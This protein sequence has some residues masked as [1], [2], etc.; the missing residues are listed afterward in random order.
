MHLEVLADAALLGYGSATPAAARIARAA[1]FETGDL[2]IENLLVEVGETSLTKDADGLI[3]LDVFKDFVI[4]LDSPGRRLEL[5]PF[6]ARTPD[7]KSR[8]CDGCMRAYRLGSLLL[9]HGTINGHADGYFVLDSGSPYS[10]VSGKLLPQDGRPAT[11]TG[12][13]GDQV[14]A[15]HSTPV[16]IQLGQRHLMDFEYATFDSTGISLR[17]GT[18][19]AGAIGYSLLRDRT[20]TIDY[21]AGMVKLS[22]SGR[23]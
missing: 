11:F 16:S 17:N 7:Q 18:E 10:M 6:P 2:R 19:I 4:R 13:Q 9:L 23:D 14:V 20:L 8:A 21:R 3:G 5:T 15:L 12:A 1:S 22:N